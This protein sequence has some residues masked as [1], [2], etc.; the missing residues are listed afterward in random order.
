MSH[1]ISTD[2]Q[3][4]EIILTGG[5]NHRT[6]SAVGY[7]GFNI[8]RIFEAYSS[9]GGTSGSGESIVLDAR[10]AENAYQNAIAWARAMEQSFPEEFDEKASEY[11]RLYKNFRSL[12]EDHPFDDAEIKTLA[13]E[14][15]QDHQHLNEDQIERSLRLLYGILNFTYHVYHHTRKGKEVDIAFV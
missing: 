6:I 9:H 15:K 14:K 11:L 1:Y 12:F 10:T 2:I 4:K 7:S 13:A 8:Y 5:S 3:G